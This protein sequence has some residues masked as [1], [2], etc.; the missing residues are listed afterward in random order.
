MEIPSMGRRRL[1]K[2]AGIAAVLATGLAPAVHAQAVVRWRLASSFPRS[3]AVGYGAA[4]TFVQ[5]VRA[6]SGGRFDIAVHA[7]GELM[8]PL[9][10]L[11]AV[12]GGSIEAAHTVPGWFHDRHPCFAIG[13]M[14]PFGPDARQT[15]AWMTAGNGRT[16]MNAFYAGQGLVALDGGSTGLQMS[17]WFR[18]A[19][20]S[21]AD[22][23]GLRLRTAGGPMDAVMARLGAV[24]QKLA[25]TGI[26][27]ALAK[28]RIDAAEWL[29]PADDQALGLGSA[30]PLYGASGWWVDGLGLGI[31]IQQ[32]ALA[33]LSSDQRA[34]IEAA[35]AQSAAMLTAR[36]DVMNAVALKQLAAAG[37][38]VVSLPQPVMQAVFS[39]WTAVAADSAA[40]NADWQRIHADLRA[41]QR[42]QGQATRLT[43]SRLEAF[44]ANRSP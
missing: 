34:M 13:S 38:K 35:A 4:E 40:K 21:A 32:K 30:A 33:A 41:F 6:L 23:K 36:Y 1:L 31:L 18:R 27:D 17:G 29:G 37:T 24:P 11:D 14:L 12:Q 8:T 39:A 43:G 5:I 2:Q 42:A 28:G 16:L 22:F 9:G 26:A 25:A 19:P 10:V 20:R 7:G 15:Q 44:M 3:S